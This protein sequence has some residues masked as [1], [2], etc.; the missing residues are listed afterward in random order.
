MAIL[1][2]AL[3]IRPS[4]TPTLPNGPEPLSALIFVVEGNRYAIRLADVV[5]VTH[6]AALM[7]PSGIESSLIGYLDL[8]G[9]VLPVL[10]VRELL[11][12]PSRALRLT[13]RFVV[14]RTG[15]RRAA[16]VVDRVDGVEDVGLIASP[17]NDRHDG[18]TIGR[19]VGAT[20]GEAIVALICLDRL[21]A[22]SAVGQTGATAS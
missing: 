21:L 1:D 22:S 12:L 17:G 4:P 14:V 10:G 5:E 9:E 18:M 3:P 6:A 13:D 8:R 15:P 11:A 2:P 7:S 19:R 20:E 16:I